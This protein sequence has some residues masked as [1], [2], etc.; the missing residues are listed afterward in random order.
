MIY[1]T[2]THTYIYTCQKPEGT[3]S[4]ISQALVLLVL[5]GMLGFNGSCGERWQGG[6]LDRIYP[7]VENDPV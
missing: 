5:L 2:Y 4:P 6:Q 7:L 1:K 3:P